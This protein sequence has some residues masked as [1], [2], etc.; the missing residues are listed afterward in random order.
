MV[1]ITFCAMP[2]FNFDI[3]RVPYFHTILTEMAAFKHENIYLK[4]RRISQK[5]PILNI[6]TAMTCV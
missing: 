3:R 4:V 2:N 5:R 1:G 6:N